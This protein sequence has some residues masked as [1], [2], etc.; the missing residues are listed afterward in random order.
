MGYVFDIV[1]QKMGCGVSSKKRKMLKEYLERVKPPYFSVDCCQLLNAG[2][3]EKVAD[4]CID[5]IIACDI[6]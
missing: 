5:R 6:F 4:I 3:Y 1:E 2:N